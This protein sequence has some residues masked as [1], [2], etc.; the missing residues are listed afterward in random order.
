MIVMVVVVVQCGFF[1]FF[2]SL[3]R[4]VLMRLVLAGH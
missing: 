2:T 1:L 4:A 3:V